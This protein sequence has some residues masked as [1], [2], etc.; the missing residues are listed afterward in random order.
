MWFF[1]CGNLGVVTDKYLI[2]VYH[3]LFQSHIRYGIL[4]WGHAPGCIKVLRLQKKAVRVL[5]AAGYRDHCK[6]LFA[7]L[8]VMTIFSQYVYYGLINLKNN[9]G[10]YQQRGDLHNHD[11]RHAQKLDIPRCRLSRSLAAHPIPAMRFYNMLPPRA[12]TEDMKAFSM[13]LFNKLTNEPL[14]SFE[15]VSGEYFSNI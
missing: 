8:K 10:E 7:N 6:P 9:I 2:N 15:E 13:Q 5:S 1:F 11:T 14:Y 3:A 4:L 12:H